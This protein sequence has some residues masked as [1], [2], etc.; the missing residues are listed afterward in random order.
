MLVFST[1]THEY[2]TYFYERSKGIRAYPPVA[3]RPS[4]IWSEREP[5]RAELELIRAP[6]TPTIPPREPQ[7]QRE[8][9]AHQYY[10]EPTNRS[11][12]VCNLQWSPNVAC[13]PCP[14]ATLTYLFAARQYPDGVVQH[15]G[16]YP[17][18]CQPES[19]RGYRQEQRKAFPLPFLKVHGM[20]SLGI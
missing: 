19:S 7:L 4:E 8:H 14:H 9:V 3:D 13:L 2:N 20:N 10:L 11:V 18:D 6:I 12:P 16:H 1:R 15:C 17:G 5:A